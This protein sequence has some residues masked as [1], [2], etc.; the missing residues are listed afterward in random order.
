MSGGGHKDMD[1]FDFSSAK[2]RKLFIEECIN[3]TRTGFVDGCFA[4]RAV[5]GTPTDSGDDTVPCDSA[6]SCR[7]KLNLTDAKATAADKTR[8][9]M[10]ACA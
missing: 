3:A 5:D 9:Q 6:H 2:A 1:V 10:R 8:D 4:D 7:F